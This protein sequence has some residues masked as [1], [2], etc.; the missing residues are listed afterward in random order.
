[1]S[2]E[3][4]SPDSQQPHLAHDDPALLQTEPGSAIAFVVELRDEH[5]VALL[6]MSVPMATLKLKQSVVML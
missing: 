5:L 2:A 3:S 4:N 6:A 1:M